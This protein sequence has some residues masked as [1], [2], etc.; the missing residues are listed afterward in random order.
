MSIVIS[1]QGEK[2]AYSEQAIHKFYQMQNMQTIE[3]LSCS[4]FAQALECVADKKADFAMIP[5]ENSIAGSVIPAY[6]E[7]IKYNLRIQHE[8]ILKVEHCLMVHPDADIDSIELVRS[9]PQALAQCQNNIARMHLSP[10]NFVDTAGAAKYIAE[11]KILTQAAIASKLAAQTY[12][13]KVIKE[14]FE[15]ES[16]NFTR[17]FLL[18]RDA[19][20]M[21]YEKGQLYK[22]SIIFTTLHKPNALV[23]VLTCLSE[24]N[25]NM[26]KIE[27]RPSRARAWDSSFFVDF[28][29]HEEQQNVQSALLAILKK[30]SFFKNLGCYQ[31]VT[32]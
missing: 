11:K 13:L 23:Q 14:H 19:L 17:F 5:V 8:V 21:P 10:K 29:G 18:G 31:S 28:E 15:D 22:S 32:L 26:C 25:I 9:H 6:D 30:T 2:G 12:S 27:S 20:N 16:F 7:L 1:F 3:T 24:H 4:S